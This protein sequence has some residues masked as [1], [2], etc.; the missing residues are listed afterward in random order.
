M[1]CNR[2]PRVRRGALTLIGVLTFAASA[3]A[4]DAADTATARALGVEGVT[5]ADAGRCSEAIDKLA[6]AERLHHAP[7]TATRLGEC[8]IEVGKLVAG[9]ERL[10]R[11]VREPLAGN[12]H[13]AFV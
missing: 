2:P 5:L 13:P 1:K 4:D 8:E 11:V 7:T 12:A 3:S 10:Q 9:S 6:R